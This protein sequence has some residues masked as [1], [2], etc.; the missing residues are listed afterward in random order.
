MTSSEDERLLIEVDVLLATAPALSSRKFSIRALPLLQELAARLRVVLKQRDD[1]QKAFDTEVRVCTA[2]TTVLDAVKAD[3]LRAEEALREIDQWNTRNGLGYEGP[4]KIARAYFA[5]SPRNRVSDPVYWLRGNRH[6]PA[7]VPT[8]TELRIR[9]LEAEIEALM[10][11]VELRGEE[12]VRL[13]AEREKLREALRAW[14]DD[15]AILA[16][17]AAVS[18]LL[19]LRVGGQTQHAAAFRDAALV[20]QQ[21][22]Q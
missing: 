22:G 17:C 16:G 12:V 10:E 18:R 21:D 7:D 14:E 11:E 8:G 13:S 4:Q 6:G 5:A 20:Q 3:R 19:M 2:R 9:R 1:L 15:V